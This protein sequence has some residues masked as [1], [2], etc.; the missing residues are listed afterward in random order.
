[1]NLKRRLTSLAVL[2]AVG[3]LAAGCAAPQESGSGGGSADDLA[4]SSGNETTT[5]VGPSLP[6]FDAT[7]GSDAGADGNA[8]ASG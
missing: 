6:G 1:M 3:V 2:L 7:A 5:E 8:T 4:D